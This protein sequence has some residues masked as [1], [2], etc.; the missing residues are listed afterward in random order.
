M[1]GGT[2]V[3]VPSRG[4]SVAGVSD[5]PGLQAALDAKVDEPLGAS[6]TLTSLGL[7]ASGGTT[8]ILAQAADHT[9]S[10]RD[11]VDGDLPSASRAAA[12]AAK[13]DSS[14]V[15]SALAGKSDTGH[16][17]TQADV[18]GLTTSSSP[19]FAGVNLG[20]ASD[21]TLGRTSAG[22]PNCEGVDLVLVS[23]TQTLT[24][25]TLT[26][27]KLASGGFIADANGNEGLILV[28][29]A[30]AVNEVTLTN[31]ATSGTPKLAATGGDTNIGLDLQA[32]GTGLIGLKGPSATYATAGPSGL[33]FPTDHSNPTSCGIWRFG[34]G[35]VLNSDSATL[36]Y[37]NNG[38]GTN[39]AIGATG[40]T[41]PNANTAI[42]GASIGVCRDSSGL[43][44]YSGDTNSRGI[45]GSS[46]Q[47]SL[48]VFGTA[49]TYRG[50]IHA[51]AR[52]I[53][54]ANSTAY[55]VCPVATGDVARVLLQDD[56]DK[57]AT[58]KISTSGVVTFTSD[59]HADY[60]ASS[61]PASGEIGCYVTAG[62]FTIK[63][64]SAGA[65]KIS[66]HCYPGAV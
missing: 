18:S 8:K 38:G 44:L 63:P 53:T 13:A 45:L 58:A 1:P 16:T 40:L 10:A 42:S 17:H 47:S 31:A 5:V 60:V 12:I 3:Y 57:S 50:A 37:F 9:V 59:S 2:A 28:T 65:R 64:G 49:H 6:D 23:A 21:T 4:G 51:T 14:A 33:L 48:A 55:S 20:H 39:G 30:S 62:V 26:A 19:Q 32:K 24:N 41:F 11:L 15:T 66:T 36:V 46:F 22:L 7:Q 35:L 54:R 52:L 34:G 27:P 25:K 61:S 43:S 29:T 56:G